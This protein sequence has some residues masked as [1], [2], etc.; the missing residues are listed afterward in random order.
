MS[1]YFF[2]PDEVT[3]TLESFG[4]LPKAEYAM[5]VEECEEKEDVHGNPY[6]KLVL[7]V[8][9]GTHRNRKLFNNLYLNHP[10]WEGAVKRG[11][12]TMKAICDA[13][14]IKLR[15]SSDMQKLIGFECLVDVGIY[16]DKNVLNSLKG[17]ASPVKKMDDVPL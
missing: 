10:E 5:C 9:E 4:L 14:G 8:T 15:S 16:K 7:T 12:G 3:E 6:I 2:N 17:K 11:R 1:E 13:M